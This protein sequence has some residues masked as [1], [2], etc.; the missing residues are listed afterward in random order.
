MNNQQIYNVSVKIPF[1]PEDVKGNVLQ[2]ER[3]KIDQLKEQGVVKHL[4]IS[5]SMNEAWM[6]INA[7]NEES[8]M[9]L[10]RTLPIFP[11]LFIDKIVQ[12]HP[13]I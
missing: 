12:L 10:M 13:N 1:I 7:D 6:I 3:Q 4:F 2:Q 5:N 11:Y 9:D 8:V